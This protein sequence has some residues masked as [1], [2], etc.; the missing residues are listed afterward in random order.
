MPAN[1]V[2][3]LPHASLALPPEYAGLFVC[4]PETLRRELLRM[5]DRYTDELFD[6]PGARRVVFGVS[7]LICDVERFRDESAE[8]MTARGMWVC[9]EKT[10]DLRPLKRVDAAHKAEILARFYDPHHA[11]LTRAV[12][13]AAEAGGCL[14]VDAHSFSSRRLPYETVGGARRD[15]C[16]GTDPFHTPPRLAGLC[17]SFLAG[18]GWS[19]GVNE[20]FAGCLI[21]MAHYGRDR[22][23]AGV[24]IEV[25][26]RLYMDEETGEKLPRFAAV[27]SLL[28]ELTAALASAL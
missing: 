2:I 6:P 27:Q 28:T 16:I 14:L 12:S 26:R 4:P 7:R 11:R 9:Y 17:R 20:P 10:S 5:T 23:V 18:R 8:S 13:R 24:M 15:F 3:H 22:R 21:P 19:V 1:L 25:N